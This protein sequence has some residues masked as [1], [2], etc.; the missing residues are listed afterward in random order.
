M[1]Q[2]A[3]TQGN[4]LSCNHHAATSPVSWANGMHIT[5]MGS[6]PFT[7]HRQ[8]NTSIPVELSNGKRLIFDIGESSPSN[9]HVLHTVIPELYLNKSVATIIGWQVE[10]LRPGSV[11]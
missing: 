4:G 10:S 11:E 2:H 8:M 5:F 3:C 1:S 7:R 6:P 9:V